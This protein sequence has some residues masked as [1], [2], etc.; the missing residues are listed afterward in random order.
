MKYRSAK[1]RQ[2]DLPE[3][4]E[5]PFHLKVDLSVLHFCRM[6]EESLP[7]NLTLPSTIHQSFFVLFCINGVPLVLGPFKVHF[8]RKLIFESDSQLVKY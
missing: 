1:Q 4:L 2:L 8:V 3:V 7:Q 5:V 6:R